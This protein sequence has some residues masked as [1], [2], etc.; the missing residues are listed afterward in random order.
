MWADSL[1]HVRV[2]GFGPPLRPLSAIMNAQRFCS[3]VVAC[4]V[5]ESGCPKSLKYGTQVAEPLTS[6]AS[7]LQEKEA[8]RK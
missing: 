7:S 8:R 6:C 5:G 4:P 2:G 3:C 1:K